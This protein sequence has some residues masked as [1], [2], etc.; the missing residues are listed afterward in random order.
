MAPLINWAQGLLLLRNSQG[1][2]RTTAASVTSADPGI[3]P[4]YADYADLFNKKVADVL[5]AHQE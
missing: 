2:P 1:D 5:P 3:P 4:E